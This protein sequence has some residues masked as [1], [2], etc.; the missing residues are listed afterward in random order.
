MH[1][2][3]VRGDRLLNLRLNRHLN[4]TLPFLSVVFNV[5][6]HLES[7]DKY[8][9]LFTYFASQSLVSLFYDLLIALKYS[10]I[11]AIAYQA[12]IIIDTYV[13]NQ[14]LMYPSDI[15]V[16]FFPYLYDPLQTC[17]DATSELL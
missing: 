6:K 12:C 3:Q 5:N 13:L 15:F 14:C 16:L 17:L 1:S 4:Q 8:H 11:C 2:H 9:C 7:I 10:C